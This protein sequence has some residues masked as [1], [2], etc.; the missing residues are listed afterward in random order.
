MNFQKQK[1]GQA[2][3]SAVIFLLFILLSILGAISHLAL[4]ESRG[5][6]RNFRGK[7]AFFAAE[8]GVEDAVYRLKRGKNVSSSFAILLNGS[9]ATT[10][11]SDISGGKEIKSSGEFLQNFRFLKAV[12]VSGGVE[13]DFFYGVQ[14]GAGGLSMGN[15]AIV[16]GNIYSNGAITG[17]NGAKIT[18]DIIAVGAIKDMIVGSSTAGTAR[19]PSFIN[20]VV[21]GSACPNQYCIVE[22]PPPKSFA[23]SQSDI[24]SWKAAAA[25]GGTCV[26]P[27]CDSSGN[28]KITNNAQA[29]LGPK[30]ITG[31]L[32]V[33]NGAI[34][35]VTG[36]IWVLGETKFS[37]NCFVKLSSSY[38]DFS[39]VIVGSEKVI[40]SNG[41]SFSG[42]GNSSSY[43]MLVSEKN[44]L[45]EEIISVDN[46]SAG[47]IYFAPNGRIKM[48]NNATAKEIT[49][50]GITLDNNAIIS[51]ESGLAN[52]A[53]SSGPSGGWS[54]NEW[55]EVV[56]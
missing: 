50:Y 12:L 35:T 7:I 37:N 15:N 51:Y 1:R 46:N 34:L 17:Q 22:N 21:H 43:I 19:A 40:I 8:A 27:Q 36:P 24:D 16:N 45:S 31:T 41:C 52:T 14:V 20:T 47:V 48:S 10:T 53:F 38:G 29:S 11:I 4:K 54:I 26:L 23:V 6:E 13:A 44:S 9:T 55:K 39:E 33:D 49:G 32:E 5:A 2:A 25:A 28:F 30:K 3:M 42:S 18:G 56:Q